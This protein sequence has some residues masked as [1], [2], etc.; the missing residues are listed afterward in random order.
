MPSHSKLFISIVLYLLAINPSVEY[1]PFRS[2]LNNLF[3]LKDRY[4]VYLPELKKEFLQPQPNDMLCMFVRRSVYSL[5]FYKPPEYRLS[6]VYKRR[7]RGLNSFRGIGVKIV[8]NFWTY[9]HTRD[10]SGFFLKLEALKRLYY[11]R[12]RLTI[13]SDNR[14][15]DKGT[16]KGLEQLSA[17]ES[18]LSK[19]NK[20]VRSLEGA[21]QTSLDLVQSKVRSGRF[22]KLVVESFR[23]YKRASLRLAEV[24]SFYTFEPMSETFLTFKTFLAEVAKKKDVFYKVKKMRQYH[25]II[26]KLEEA[27]DRVLGYLYI[28]RWAP[29]VGF[30][31]PKA[32]KSL[33]ELYSAQLKTLTDEIDKFAA[34]RDH[35]GGKIKGLIQSH[36]CQVYDTLFA[37][38][39]YQAYR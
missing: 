26:R 22:R 13:N 24:D 5:P 4:S 2:N 9:E 20:Q 36:L 11:N 31:M 39:E 16:K 21:I 6:R 35:W 15:Y 37:D 12:Y 10:Q 23:E 8:E 14:A 27:R 33:E 18:K 34:K 32:A 29:R 17:A 3:I 38:K 25:L 7:R 1:I 28:N 30:Q 19:I